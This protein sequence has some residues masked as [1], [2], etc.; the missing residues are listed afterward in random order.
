[1]GNDGKRFMTLRARHGSVLPGQRK[2]GFGVVECLDGGPSAGGMTGLAVR[3]GGLFVPVFMTAR[4]ISPQSEECRPGGILRQCG[5][6]NSEPRLIVAFGAL[7][8]GVFSIQIEPGLLMI[9]RLR[10][11]PRDLNIPAKMLLVA[12]VACTGG[13][14]SMHAVLAG[15]Q[16]SDLRMTAQTF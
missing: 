1:M 12:F 7:K 8:A 2:M 10:R 16:R 13:R 4:A 9:E 6:L 11:E 14:E 3:S 5:F 15:D